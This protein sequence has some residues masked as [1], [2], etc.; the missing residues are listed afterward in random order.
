MVQ[1][2][3]YELHAIDSGYYEVLYARAIPH[4]ILPVAFGAPLA[5]INTINRAQPRPSPASADGPI[6]LQGLHLSEG[7]GLACTKIS[8]VRDWA[9]GKGPEGPLN[10]LNS[11]LNPGMKL[12]F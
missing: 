8:Y 12:F 5:V 4:K 7:K 6:P 1:I 10:I 9:S 11:W 2:G 3:P